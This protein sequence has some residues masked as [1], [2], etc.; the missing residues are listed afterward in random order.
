MA[1][2]G[3]TCHDM[4]WHEIIYHYI[5]LQY[6]TQQD[7]TYQHK[8]DH[9]TPSPRTTTN[10]EKHTLAKH[11]TTLDCTTF[12]D[13]LRDLT[14]H[15][16]KVLFTLD[17]YPTYNYCTELY[18][19]M[20]THMH[21]YFRL[22][23]F[24]CSTLLDAF[25]VQQSIL[26][27]I[28][29]LCNVPFWGFLIVSNGL[30][31]SKWMYMEIQIQWTEGSAEVVFQC[32]RVAYDKC[33]SI[34]SMFVIKTPLASVISLWLARVVWWRGSHGPPFPIDSDTQVEAIAFAIIVIWT[35]E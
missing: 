17:T 12:F 5:A 26:Q 22:H 10:S 13:K 6:I 14:T 21:E 8:K 31:V 3:M 7:P 15:Y 23:T 2:H 18:G 11:N 29:L 28:I 24:R 16:D 32:C 33:S 1:W 19:T 34:H 35:C 9:N 4:T 20:H 30:V 27:W 25:D